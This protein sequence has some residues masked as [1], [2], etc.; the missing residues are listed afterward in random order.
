M[1]EYYSAGGGRHLRIG[2]RLALLN[3]LMCLDQM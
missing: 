1:L 2:I 3:T